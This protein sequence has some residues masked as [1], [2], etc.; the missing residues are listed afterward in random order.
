MSKHSIV[1]GDLVLVHWWDVYSQASWTSPKALPPPVLCETVGRVVRY[2]KTDLVLAA[3]Q[4]LKPPLSVDE[5]I[6]DTTTLPIGVV[7]CV[8]YLTPKKEKK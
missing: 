3:T 7:K 8:Y 1:L 2:T 6:S 4:Q 5:T